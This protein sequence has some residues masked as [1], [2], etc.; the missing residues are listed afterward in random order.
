M[1]NKNAWIVQLGREAVDG[2]FET[3]I[4]AITS[5]PLNIRGLQVEYQAPG[6]GVIHFDWEDDLTLDGESIPL[7]NYPRW[8]NP[9]TFAEANS[10]QYTI[11]H[12]SLRLFVDFENGV[13]EIGP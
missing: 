6:L 12:D 8:E 4:S 10:Q 11:E 5:A 2:S 13:R 3:F 7:D 9:Y 1:G